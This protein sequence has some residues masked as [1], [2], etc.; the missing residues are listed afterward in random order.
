MIGQRAETA[1]A[2]Y[3][4]RQGYDIV[5]RNWRCRYCEIDIV[6][7]KAES[8]S[9]VEVKYR[10]TSWQGR[11]T[12]YITPAKLRQMRF[13]AGLWVSYFGWDQEYC[14]AV[15]SVCGSQFAIDQFVPN[16]F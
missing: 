11:G 7:Q 2:E 6:A 15:I 4:V 5:M 8:L 3:L 12:D 14:L 9:F 13:A 1:A 16:L 10:R